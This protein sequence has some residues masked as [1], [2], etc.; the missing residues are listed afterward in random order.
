MKI[1]IKYIFPIFNYNFSK[2][3]VLEQLNPTQHIQKT[4]IWKILA[5]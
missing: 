2:R 5:L 3:I 4:L 1:H